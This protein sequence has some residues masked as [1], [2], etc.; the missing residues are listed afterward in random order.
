MIVKIK[1]VWKICFS[2]RPKD[3]L[4]KTAVN[5]EAGT[6]YIMTVKIRPP[7]VEPKTRAPAGGKVAK[8]APFVT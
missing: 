6:K 4:K 3:L 2:E 1:A 5:E 8:V 7:F